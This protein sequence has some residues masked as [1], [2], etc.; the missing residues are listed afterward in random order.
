MSSSSP[1]D[2][3]DVLQGQATF[4]LSVYEVLIKGVKLGTDGASKCTRCRLRTH[5]SCRPRIKWQ[6]ECDSRR[7]Q[8]VCPLTFA[9]PVYTKLKATRILHEQAFLARLFFFLY[10]DCFFYQERLVCPQLYSSNPFAATC[11]LVLSTTTVAMMSWMV[12]RSPCHGVVYN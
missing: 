5:R 11:L 8:N 3:A 12:M 6:H 1:Y 7:T 9:R 4:V 10:K 2:T